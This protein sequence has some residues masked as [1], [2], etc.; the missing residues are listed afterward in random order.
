MEL[1]ITEFFNNECPRDFSASCAEIGQ[2]A[3]RV[4]YSAAK[5]TAPEYNFLDTP[6]K[7]EAYRE[8]L[9]S[10][11]FGDD[12]DKFSALELN[13]IFLQDISASIRDF[14]IDGGIDWSE[15]YELS[16][17]GVL[18]GALFQANDGRIYFSFEE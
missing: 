5:E 15:Y 9:R 16:E 10:L 7:Q 1:N 13:A 12:A 6:E 17:Q 14:E 2:D 4:T 8:N 3:G 11:G 18:S